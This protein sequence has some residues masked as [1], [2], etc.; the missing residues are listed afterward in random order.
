VSK[1]GC[2][3]GEEKKRRG[4]VVVVGGDRRK[5]SFLVANRTA[6]MK[7]DLQLLLLLLAASG[8]PFSSSESLATTNTNTTENATTSTSSYNYSANATTTITTNTSLPDGVTICDGSGPV[9][10]AA[11]ALLQRPLP[12]CM[13]HGV[14][15]DN[16]RDLPEQP[17]I[18][19]SNFVGPHC[20]F[21]KGTEPLFLE[22]E[23]CEKH[24]FWGKCQIGAKSFELVFNNNTSTTFTTKQDLQYC[25]CPD[26][27]SGEYCERESQTC[28]DGSHCFNGG[29]CVTVEL[30][31][32]SREAY[33]DCTTAYT[34][35]EAFAGRYCE[36]KVTTFCSKE[37]M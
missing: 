36:H 5:I 2:A 21:Q 7:I 9:G 22:E 34:G 30:E 8:F 28:V 10:A 27:A 11:A 29:S 31:D 32:G 12:Y 20:E 1:D 15:A 3:A 18:C 25:L 14:C 6:A 24:C 17:C 4:V 16:Y 23:E 26:Y 37:G 13:N 33:C 35:P 19:S